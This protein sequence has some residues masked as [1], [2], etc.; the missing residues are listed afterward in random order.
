MENGLWVQQGTCR[1]SLRGDGGL[2]PMLVVKREK[3]F[4]QHGLLVT[5]E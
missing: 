1:S 4:V 2:A 5:T 3:S